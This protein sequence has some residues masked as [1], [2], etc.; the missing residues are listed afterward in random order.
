S[1]DCSA[2]AGSALYGPTARLFLF[3]LCAP[4]GAMWFE[5]G[6][7]RL[8]ASLILDVPTMGASSKWMGTST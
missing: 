7:L 3:Q 5:D 2:S 8:R 1:L 4:F 6:L